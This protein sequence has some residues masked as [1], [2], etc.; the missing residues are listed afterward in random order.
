MLSLSKML[1]PACIQLELRASEK[2]EVVQ[3]LVELFV[4]AGKLE[5]PDGLVDELLTQEK[6]VSTGIGDGIAIPHKLTKRV[7]QTMIAFGRKKNGLNFESLDLQPVFLL[8]LILGPPRKVTEHLQV[9]SKLSRL[10]HN[11]NFRQELLAAQL[12]NEIMEI[13]QRYETA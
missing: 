13:L 8:F 1:D 2:M 5:H 12:P 11:K 7:K 9:L 10:L 6:R 4:A 3:E